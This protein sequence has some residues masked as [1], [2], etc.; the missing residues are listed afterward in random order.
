MPNTTFLIIG[1]YMLDVAGPNLHYETP[2]NHFI[3]IV[4]TMYNIES[5]V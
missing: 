3:N 2:V 5:I 4:L 1:M